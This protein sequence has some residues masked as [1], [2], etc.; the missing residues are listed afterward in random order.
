MKR[1]S[2]PIY[3]MNSSKYPARASFFLRGRQW[4]EMAQL[5]PAL[6]SRD[7]RET[8]TGSDLS[9][10]IA[11][12]TKTAIRTGLHPLIDRLRRRGMTLIADPIDGDF[13]DDLLSRFDCVI[14]AA[15]MQEAFFR[16]TLPVRVV[17]V[18]HHVD[19]RLPSFRPPADRFSMG[20]FGERLNARHRDELQNDIEFV[21]MKTNAHDDTAWMSALARHNAHYLLRSRDKPS[22][23][24][25]F[26]KGF[27]AARLG[28]PV[29]I[30]DDD[31]EARHFLP[32]DYPYRVDA[33]NLGAVRKMVARMKDDFGQGAWRRACD[34]MMCVEEAACNEAIAAQLHE[35]LSPYL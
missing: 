3:F 33:D 17:Y 14:A 8:Q 23:F 18:G 5:H 13:P 24:K 34:M 35:A 6:S 31:A 11:I 1:M 4:I 10:G 19:L 12:L 32:D 25:P 9:G 30:G 27:I 7:L 29:L 2:Q 16:A 22:R 20:Y 21:F 26:T 28:A 15:R